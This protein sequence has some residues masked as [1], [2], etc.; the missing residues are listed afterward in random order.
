[1]AS[2]LPLGRLSALIAA[3]CAAWDNRQ[4]QSPHDECHEGFS[5]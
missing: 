5:N 4:K 2:L 3:D 1:M